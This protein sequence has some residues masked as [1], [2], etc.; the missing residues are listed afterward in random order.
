VAVVE[1]PKTPTEVLAGLVAVLVHL[2]QEAQV[3]LVD[4]THQKVITGL[5]TQVKAAAAAVEQVALGQIQML[6][7]AQMVELEHLH[8]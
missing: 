1:H 6:K 3:I 2:P 5:Q 8:L 7:Q 4:I